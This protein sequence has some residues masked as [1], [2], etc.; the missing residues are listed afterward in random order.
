MSANLQNTG[1]SFAPLMDWLLGPMRQALLQTALELDLPGLLTE[2]G[3]PQELAQRLGAHQDNLVRLLDGLTALGL[4][5][6]HSGRYSNTPLADRYLRRDR[7]TWL[8]DMLLSLIPMQQSNLGRLSELVLQ[9]PSEGKGE[10][11]LDSPEHW[12]RAARYLANYQRAGLGRLAADLAEALPEF[13]GFRRM[14]DLGG[15]P[16]LV[17]AAILERHPSLH[18]VLCDQ[19]PVAAVAQELAQ[20]QGLAERMS[21]IAGDYNQADLGQG[22]DLIWTSHSLYY[23]KDRTAFMERLLQ[24]LNPGGVLLC[25]H[26]GLT[27]ER[28][29][30]P[31]YVLSRLSLALEGQDVSF[32]QGEL[33]AHMRQAGFA[34]VES[35][36]IELA[37]GLT[38]LDVGRKARRS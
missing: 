32:D 24:A 8:G 1:V 13:P 18:C 28:S 16:G 33:A 5:E 11:R 31:Y 21:F 17:G 38:W 14:L 20:A 3:D 19:P 12:E 34:R 25:L 27:A 37:T 2:T 35:Q 15:G 6:K 4:A 29:H 23:V 9:G 22:Y 10:Q 26:E 7:Q 30:P 36:S